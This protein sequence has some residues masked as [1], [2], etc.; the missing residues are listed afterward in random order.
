MFLKKVVKDNKTEKKYVYYRLCES[1]RI[2]DKTRHTILLNL[3][4]L[5]G[6]DETERKM[7]ANRIEALYQGH[8][9]FLDQT[10][11]SVEQLAR[12]FYTL[13]RE[14]TKRPV[15][16]VN[17]TDTKKKPES[18]A[19]ATDT[20]RVD[21]NT[22][23]HDEVREIG[24]EHVCLQ[25]IGELNL[26]SF[27]QK[28]H[29]GKEKINMA[30]T[31]I[32]SR[33]VY[34]ASEHKT[35]QWIA[36]NS[37]IKELLFKENK[38]ISYQ[39]L[40]K[41]SKALYAEK[42]TIE[43]HLSTKTNE[44]FDLPDKIILYDLTN[45]YFEGRKQASALARFGRSKEKRSDAKPVSLALVVNAE[46]FVKYSKIYQGNI[47]EP[48]TLAATVEALSANTDYTN[49]KSTVV[50]GAGIATEENLLFL[51]QN[52]YPYLCVT[53]SKLKDY[54]PAQGAE[55]C[56]TIADNRGN[57]IH[58]QKV[59]KEDS[60][61]QFMYIH[62]EMKTV[63]EVSMGAHFST[64]YEDELTR[65]AKSIQSKGGV[66]NST[67]VHERLG[68]IKERYPSANKHYD[69]AVKDKNN[70]ATGLTFKR[71]EVKTTSTDG[72][73]FIRTSLPDID[74]KKPAKP[75]AWMWDIYNTLTEVEATFRILKTDLSL[76][77]VFH[78]KDESTEAHIQLGILAYAVVNT[79]RYKL[80]LQGI[81]H[82]WK[83]IV[84]ILNTQKLVS[85]SFKK[86][87]GQMM[88]IKKCSQPNSEA[89]VIYQA[90]NYKQMPFTM[91]KF[92]FPH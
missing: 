27:L 6:L 45:T 89:T 61:D 25:A 12:K 19:V 15:A 48:Q 51:K 65:L 74:E 70:L 62:S 10:P 68:R 75:T 55:Q 22:I 47:S 58:L 33:A 88:M 44:L 52:S 87:N 81:H 46:G 80:K 24:A 18:L 35:A 86:E 77:P 26:P 64:R 30:L 85:T 4:P 39:Q 31:H 7:L 34:P 72:V 78:Q 54:R 43:K 82:D 14:K 29:W 50:L 53:R 71:K 83:N 59:V 21:I 37:G 16:S 32:V 11:D 38:N 40:Y 28:L 13:L 84:R 90:L 8:T 41:L 1:I 3:G 66:K 49:G 5:P 20:Q 73:Y 57:K 91:K 9:T 63:K 17:T 42:E 60:T 56:T 79:I 23:Q 69:V 92:V 67:K 76:R 2:G 36:G